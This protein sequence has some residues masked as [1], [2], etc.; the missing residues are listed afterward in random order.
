[1]NIGVPVWLGEFVANHGSEAPEGVEASYVVKLGMTAR[2]EAL[3]DDQGGVWIHELV[4][5][6]PTSEPQ[7]SPLWTRAQAAQAVG[8]I[9]LGTRRYPELV[10]LMPHRPG[11]A[12]DCAG[13]SGTGDS[14]RGLA[15]AECFGLGWIASE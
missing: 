10:E 5:M 12:A 6:A 7:T 3:L 1:M 2:H 14:P 8:A 9:K 4:W 13:C 11:N 15:C